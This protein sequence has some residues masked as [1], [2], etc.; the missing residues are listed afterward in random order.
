MTN[1]KSATIAS[2]AALFALTNMAVATPASAAPKA[3]AETVHCYGI[4]TCKGTSDCKT[5]KNDCKGQ[6]DCKGMG[7]KATTAKACAKAGGSLTAPQ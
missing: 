7:F 6:N 1:L 3:K 2:A 4:N 5:A